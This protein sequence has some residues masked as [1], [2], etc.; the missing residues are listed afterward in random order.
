MNLLT[1]PDGTDLSKNV[2]PEKFNSLAFLSH[3][4]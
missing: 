2:L 1:I 3:S 4:L